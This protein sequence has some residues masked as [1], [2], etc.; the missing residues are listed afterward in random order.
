MPTL[1]LSGGRII[2]PASGRDSPGDLVIDGAR[3]VSVA[4]AGAADAASHRIDCSGFLVVPGLV[5][6]HV[7]LREPPFADRGDPAAFAALP[8]TIGTGAAAAVAGGFTAVCAMPNTDPPI[9]TG[10]AVAWYMARGRDAGL[11]RVLV[12][13]CLTRG[14][15][16]REVA[17]LEA[18]RDAGAVAFTDDGS[19]VADDAVF[20]AALVEAARLAMPVLCHCEDAH[21]AAGGV[22]H[23]GPLATMLGLPGIPREAEEVA[24]D[25]ACTAADRTGCR[26]HIMHV[27]T[28]EAVRRVRRAKAE[29][30]PVTAEATPHHLALIADDLASRNTVFKVNPPLRTGHDAE[31]VLEAV[32]DGTI[33]CLATDHAPHTAAAKGRRLAE[34]PPGMIGLESALGIYV[35]TFIHTP[36]LEWPALIGRLTVGPALALGLPK[37]SLAAGAPADLTVIDPAAVWTVDPDQFASRGRNC[38]FAGRQVYGRVVRTVVGGQVVYEAGGGRDV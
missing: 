13:G 7:H 11:A 34:A 18:M 25:R 16:G 33:D 20:E 8:E 4:D 9:D 29:G 23:A 19:D 38:P 27:S 5:D 36:L 21:L 28:E 35:D 37:P 14:R 24:V 12:A 15:A 17:D 1:V 2:D 32:R 26:V 3:I 30:V 22:L 31:A 10:E 6:P